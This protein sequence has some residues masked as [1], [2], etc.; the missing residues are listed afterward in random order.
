L[1]AVVSLCL[2]LPACE[3]DASRAP[4]VSGVPEDETADQ[5]VERINDEMRAMYRELTASQWLSSTYINSDS[6]LLAAK[7]NER[8]LTALN[9]WVEQARRFEGQEMSPATARAIS[10]LKLGTAMPPPR[11][12]AK[13][14][15]LTQ[16]ATRMEGMY[17]AGTYCAEG[18]SDDC[19]QLGQL[20]DVLRSDRDYDRQLDAWQG[21]H[22]IAQ[23]M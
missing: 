11:D 3:R 19:R 4:A 22:S 2:A 18:R 13:L 10:L 15:E 14:A 1:L 12:P 6:Q 7:G 23:P 16:I 5:F 8:W 21:W 17:G 20:E 9:S